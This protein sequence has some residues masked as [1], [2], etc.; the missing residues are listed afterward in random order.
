MPH[1]GNHLLIYGTKGSIEV[2]GAMS[3][4][5][6]KQIIIKTD[7][8][9]EK[10]EYVQENLY[11]NEVEDFIKYYFNNDK[12][13]ICD[14]NIDDGILALKLIEDMRKQI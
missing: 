2:Y 14:T 10:M 6:I 4:K 7:D 12:T 1:A 13:A 5:A 8:G 9:E 11:K 3:E